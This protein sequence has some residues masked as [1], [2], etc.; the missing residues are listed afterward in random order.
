MALPDDDHV[1]QLTRKLYWA[2]SSTFPRLTREEKAKTFSWAAQM[3]ERVIQRVHP[4]L[5]PPVDTAAHNGYHGQAEGRG[6]GRYD[7]SL[8]RRSRALPPPNMADWTLQQAAMRKRAWGH[9]MKGRAEE[10]QLPIPQDAYREVG[11]GR[12]DSSG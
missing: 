4:S 1:K 8:P 10:V 11:N 3:A 9:V 7:P 2:I 12:T 6:G 5:P